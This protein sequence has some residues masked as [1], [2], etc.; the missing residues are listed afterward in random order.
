[1]ST[2][3]KLRGYLAITGALALAVLLGACG[4]TV[5]PT[6]L[7]A[8]IDVRKLN[9]GKYPTE[10]RNAHDDAYVPNFYEMGKVAAMRLSDHVVSAYEID[11]SMKYGLHSGTIPGRPDELGD[12]SAVEQI[13]KRNKMMFG[14]ESQ[15]S[16]NASTF[17]AF[18]GWPVPSPAK[19][20]YA[21]TMVMQFPD[22]DRARTAAAEFHEADFATFK[23]SNQRI[24]LPKHPT[25]QSHWRPDAPVL[26]T[27][28]AHGSYVVA[29]LVSTP[30]TDLTALT[31]L[32]DRA[33]DLQ[34]AQLDQLP[35]LIAAQTIDLPWDPDRLLDR[36]LDPDG[37]QLKP[38]YDDDD[39]F[40]SGSHG[41]LHFAKDR[42]LA[43]TRFGARNIGRFA[44]LG[45][46]PVIQL[47]DDDAARA[48]VRDRI[49]MTAV[50]RDAAAPPDLPDSACVENQ[51]S[52]T[53][54]KRFTCIVAYHR[55][56]GFVSAN[57]LGDA[58]QQAAAQ[59]ALFANNR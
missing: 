17:L 3:R 25:A 46:T 54:S 47:A 22:A 14:F 41:M 9:V 12:W 43:D 39:G 13:I 29:F 35:A 6:A 32:A 15:G 5:S 34:L 37:K 44:A 20:R 50:A 55:Y 21:A 45:R 58:Q 53:K 2:T 42:E 1:M 52:A 24:S 23:D 10:P 27:V 40:V 51:E 30:E 16:D 33:Y 56:V 7:P 26:R 36:V 28:L 38:G 19:S 4:T 57:Q 59:Y 11:K 49:T 31:T 48:V 8:E 18:P